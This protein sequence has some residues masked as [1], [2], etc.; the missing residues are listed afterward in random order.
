MEAIVYTS[1]TGT[2][3]AYALL[4]GKHTGLPVYSLNEARKAVAGGTEI[5]YLGWLLAGT[6]KDYGKAARLYKAA[7][8]CGVCMGTT[9]SQIREIRAKCHIPEKT[10]VFTMQGGFDITKL[11]GIYKV[12]M[13]VMSKAVG[14]KLA[15]K[16]NRTTEEDAVLEMILHGANY[17]S[18]NNMKEL[19]E[20]Y[21][22]TV[23]A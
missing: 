19:F 22:S 21:D 3:K 8:V 18:E 5:I 10:A 23:S 13:K 4:L 20:W 12:M 2:T 14:K 15:S 17:V 16:K 9:G 11:H 6:V 1:N 7:A